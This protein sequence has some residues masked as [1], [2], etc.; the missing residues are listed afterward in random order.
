MQAVLTAALTLI[1]GSVLFLFSQLITEGVIKPYIEY[2]RLLADI[3]YTLVYRGN[4]IVSAPAGS[5]PDEHSEV[6]AKLRQLAAQLRSSITA[7]P[8][9]SSFACSH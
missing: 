5:M 8:F 7:L 2:R 1:G 3:T 6:S 4:I 9:K